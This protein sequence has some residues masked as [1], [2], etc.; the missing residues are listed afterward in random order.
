MS[1]ICPL[2]VFR[3]LSWMPWPFKDNHG[4][5]V[6]ST[7]PLITCECHLSSF[8][9]L[10]MPSFLQFLNA[11]LPVKTEQEKAW[12][13]F[14]FNTFFVYSLS[15]AFNIPLLMFLVWKIFCLGFWIVVLPKKNL[16]GTV[17][18]SVSCQYKYSIARWSNTFS[19]LLLLLFMYLEN[20]L[21]PPTSPET[22]NSTPGGLWLSHIISYIWP[23]VKTLV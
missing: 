11:D 4:S 9:D 19:L 6:T 17:P 1:D 13:G 23:L 14:A 22:L 18:N 2:V 5:I 8:M 16:Y 12:N 3:D 15:D 21:F 20:W 10:H 7:S